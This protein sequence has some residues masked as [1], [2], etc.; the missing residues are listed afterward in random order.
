LESQGNFMKLIHTAFEPEG[1]GPFPA[2]I[3][4]HGWG[5]SAFDLL[6][7]APY[8]ADG[9]FLMLCPQG[10]IEVPLG[11]GPVGYG[12]YPISMGGARPDDDEI[13]SAVRAAATF[14]DEAV[15]RYPIDR[16]KL[17]VLGFSQGGVMAYNLSLRQPERFAALVGI[18]TWFPPE[19]AQKVVNPE[20]LAQL[21]T[22]IQHG[23]ADPAI[24]VTRAR[25][26]VETLRALKV[27][28]SYREYD[29]GHEIPAQGLRDLSNFL[30]EKVVSPIIRV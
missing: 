17:V 3:A 30:M 23:S 11:G 25:Q 4:F 24:E 14:L 27:P 10:P 2:V 12:W 16:R 15:A 19:L 20:A 13:E 1:E 28:L 6:G 8:M 21:P 5:A 18:S 9:R 7:L 22:L 29:C 26:S